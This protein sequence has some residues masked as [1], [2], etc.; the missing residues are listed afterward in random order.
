MSILVTRART[1][2][3][4]WWKHKKGEFH[5][6]L[7]HWNLLTNSSWQNWIDDNWEDQL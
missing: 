4:I 7:R 6:K 1:A 2:S 3:V 5:I